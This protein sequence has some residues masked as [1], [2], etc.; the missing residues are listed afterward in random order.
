MRYCG[1]N[2]QA[3]TGRDFL[4]RQQGYRMLLDAAMRMVRQVIVIMQDGVGIR[5]SYSKLRLLE[6]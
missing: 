6:K 3:G 2:E 4:N 5:A 1:P